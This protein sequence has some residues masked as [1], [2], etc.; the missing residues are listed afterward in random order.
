MLPVAVLGTRPGLEFLHPLA[1]TMLGGLVSLL[2]VQLFVLPA[3]LLGTTARP[4]PERPGHRP[5]QPE[6]RP[7]EP[8]GQ[9]G[10]PGAPPMAPEV[11]TPRPAAGTAPG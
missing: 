10:Q 1:V 6:P 9:S 8:N 11:T 3:L 2:V 7:E 4:R 5:A